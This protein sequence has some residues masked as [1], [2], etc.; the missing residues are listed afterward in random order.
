MATFLRGT[1]LIRVNRFFHQ[2]EFT[3]RKTSVYRLSIAYDVP[4][5]ICSLSFN[6]Y[7]T[8]NKMVRVCCRNTFFVSLSSE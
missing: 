1:L 2:D 4:I 8:E 7:A 6:E 5:W 3:F